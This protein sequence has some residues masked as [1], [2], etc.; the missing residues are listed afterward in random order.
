MYPSEDKI[1]SVIK[2]EIHASGS[3]RHVAPWS[4]KDAES[5]YVTAI[6]QICFCVCARSTGETSN[7]SRWI[8]MKKPPREASGR[9]QGAFLTLRDSLR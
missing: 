9:F 3:L 7:Q 4:R 6:A 1:P 8:G 2:I 5:P